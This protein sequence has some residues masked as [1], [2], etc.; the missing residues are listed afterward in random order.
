MRVDPPARAWDLVWLPWAGGN[1]CAA[2]KRVGGAA[3][4]CHLSEGLIQL[5]RGGQTFR[6]DLS[7]F[8]TILR[9]LQL[10]RPN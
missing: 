6:V 10:I 3:Q 5:R 7:F 8:F 1:A 9:Q 2:W 4:G